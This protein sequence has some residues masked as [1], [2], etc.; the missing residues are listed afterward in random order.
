MR[1]VVLIALVLLGGTA[2]LVA[3]TR[4][5]TPTG[6]GSDAPAIV[7]GSSRGAARPTRRDPARLSAVRFLAAFVR[8]EAGAPPRQWRSQLRRNATSA[9]ASEL[10]KHPPRV[11]ARLPGARLVRVMVGRRSARAAT[12][13]ARLD[14]GGRRSSL[15]LVLARYDGWRVAELGR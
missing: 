8:Y 5:D 13:L 1:A 12:V 7:G 9:F 14:R 2:W 4:R 11:P 3:A 6:R 15:V 10:G